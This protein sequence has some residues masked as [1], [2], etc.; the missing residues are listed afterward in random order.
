MKAQCLVLT[1]AL[2][3]ALLLAATSASGAET[4]VICTPTGVATFSGR[5]HV[6][7]AQSFSGIMF[8]AHGSGDA[9]GAARYMSMATSALILF[10]PRK[11][12]YSSTAFVFFST[13]T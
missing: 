7:C 11:E 5:I 13:M 1:G 8:F 4:S 2:V 6:R 10:V 12:L 9:A 3:C